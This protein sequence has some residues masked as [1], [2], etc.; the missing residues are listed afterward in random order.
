MTDYFTC[1]SYNNVDFLI[2]NKYVRAGI[3]YQVNNDAKSIIY[4]KETLPLIYIGEA[5]EKEFFCNSENDN[6]IVLVMNGY[7]FSKEICSR[8]ISYTNTAFPA[9]GN[10]AISLNGSITSKLIEITDLRLIPQ[11]IRGRMSE[12]GIN[13]ISFPSDNN[14]QILISPDCLLRKFFTGG[15]L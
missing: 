1:I 10:V 2:Q 4:N 15:Q 8:I 3:Y 9:S 14:K 7:D 11:S 5:I 6:G 13:A 12:C